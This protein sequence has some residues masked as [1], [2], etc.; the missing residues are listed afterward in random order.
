MYNWAI[1][2]VVLVPLAN[3]LLELAWKPTLSYRTL[4]S[5]GHIVRMLELNSVFT[6]VY[7][8]ML[9]ASFLSYVLCVCFAYLDWKKLAAEGVVRPFHW[10][11]A[12]LAQAVYVIGR[13]VVVR[14]VA[15]RGGLAPIWALIATT[16]LAVVVVG[17]KVA[18][19]FPVV[20]SPIPT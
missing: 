17:V 15:Q 14:K 8:L 12:F 19:M 6:P 10:G 9:F 20:A 4:V 5:S 18:G 3:V 7:F 1:W 16:V 13:S 2:L 11:W